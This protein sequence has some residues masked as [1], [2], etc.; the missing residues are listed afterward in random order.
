MEHRVPCPHCGGSV[1]MYRNPAPTV[2]ILI[3]E[4]GRGIVLIRRRNEPPG[5]ALPGG[6]IDYGESAEAAAV[7][8]AREETGLDVELTGLVGVYS[9]PG[10]DPRHHTLSVVYAARVRGGAGAGPATG[11]AAPVA[12][13]PSAAPVAGDDAAD[14]RF[15]MPDDLPHPMAFDH[16]KIIADWLH[17][18]G[19]CP[20][21]AADGA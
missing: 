9:E 1:V 8:E 2:D 3:H 4:P 6:F 15:F 14:A 20:G 5:W 7:R 18:R 17:A 10:R 13:G 19:C 11:D 16:A 12:E 21:H